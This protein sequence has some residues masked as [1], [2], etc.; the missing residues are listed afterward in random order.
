[1]SINPYKNTY[2]DIVRRA[3]VF[4]SS[5]YLALV[6][7]VDSIKSLEKAADSL[8]KKLPQKDFPAE[9]KTLGDI[10]DNCYKLVDTINASIA[11]INAVR[12]KLK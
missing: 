8:Q 6:D 7:R 9:F 12:I 5:S 4:G 3:R 11:K 2:D 1:M 10:S